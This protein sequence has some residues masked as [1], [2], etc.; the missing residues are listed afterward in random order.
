[1]KGGGNG[2]F[3]MA[4]DLTLRGFE[5][6]LFEL[7]A[8]AHTLEPVLQQGG[9]ALRGVVGEG[10]ARLALVTA[11]IQAALD[12]ADA[13]MVVVPA[14]GHRAM[15]RA[16]APFLQ[17]GQ[18]VVLTPGCC[19][20]AL[21]FRQELRLHGNQADVGLAESTSL[22]YA[23]KKE[24]G[25]RVWARGV[26]Q[27]LPLAALP[28]H[29]TT[30]VIE[31][32]RPAFS[33][34][35]PAVNVLDTSFNNSNHMTH[36]VPMLMNMGLVESQRIEEWFF[37]HDGYTPGTGRAGEQLDAE[38]LAIVR[39][40]DLPEVSIVEWVQRYYG[41]QGMRGDTLYELFSSSP[42]HGPTRGPRTTKSRLITEDIPYGLVPLAS[43]GRL[44]G[45]P[46]PT[47]DA[48]ITLAGVVNETNYW[49]A[50]RTI[51]SLGLAGMTVDEMVHL[52]SEG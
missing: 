9:I 24:G 29:Q 14:I 32:L 43:F 4:A 26:K 2:G 21:E 5:V 23:V 38:R 42:V 47:M 44:A 45:V 31:R 7:P 37:Y 30:A 25:H 10:F 52:V 39:A 40:F 15:A 19:G 34:F 17:N 28:A 18:V 22:M 20:G 48:L 41:H 51:E 27:G 46:T 8:F 35:V 36:P 12:G 3:C 13:I 49:Q 33:H 1:G 11:D 50:G 16:C 6:R